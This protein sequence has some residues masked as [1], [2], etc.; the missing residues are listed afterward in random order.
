[1]Y[2]VVYVDDL[3]DLLCM[4]MSTS[5]SSVSGAAVA[6]IEVVYMPSVAFVIVSAAVVVVAGGASVVLLAGIFV[7]VASGVSVVA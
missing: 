3:P 7:V 1:M 6:A 4:D 5:Q 2:L